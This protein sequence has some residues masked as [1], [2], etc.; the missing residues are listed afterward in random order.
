MDF[1][2]LWTLP[3]VGKI[4]GH[5]FQKFFFKL[6]QANG[7]RKISPKVGGLIKR[8]SVGLITMK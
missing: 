2:A 5:A 1:S 6:P 3:I 4:L 8:K 7:D